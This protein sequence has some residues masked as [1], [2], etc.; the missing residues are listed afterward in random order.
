MSDYIQ[1]ERIEN[2]ES[3]QIIK[4]ECGGTES[5][6]YRFDKTEEE[7]EEMIHLCCLTNN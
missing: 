1:V 3:F 7:V 2:G 5:E 4:F 6:F